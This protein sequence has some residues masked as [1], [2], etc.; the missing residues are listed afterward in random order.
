MRLSRLLLIF[1]SITLFEPALCAQQNQKKRNTRQNPAQTTQRKPVAKK[2]LT[3][4]QKKQMEVL[5]KINAL[6]RQGKAEPKVFFNAFY[7]LVRDEC[8]NMAD[9]NQKRLETLEERL[10]AAESQGDENRIQSLYKVIEI[11]RKSEK[12]SKEI[13]TAIKNE[14]L[15]NTLK[16]I[17]EYLK[18]EQELRVAKYAP[19]ARN[20]FTW[21]ETEEA[22][23]QNKTK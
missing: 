7:S 16:S 12:L 17:D 8:Q 6:K 11:Y 4:T 15:G 14:K 5:Q 9:L 19:V 13:E 18:L 3:P 20:W 1:I 21:Q 22:I 23:R 10:K 2:P